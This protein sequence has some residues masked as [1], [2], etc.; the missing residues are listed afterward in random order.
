MKRGIQP[1]LDSIRL[2]G[3][4]FCGDDPIT[5]QVNGPDEIVLEGCGHI[6]DVEGWAD[7]RFES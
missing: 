5:I 1:I 2:D 6:V 3:C 4:P 7:A